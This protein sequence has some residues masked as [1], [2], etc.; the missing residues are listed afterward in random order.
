MTNTLL[1]CVC[2]ED[3]HVW[4]KVCRRFRSQTL[5]NR[6]NTFKKIKT[7]VNVPRYTELVH[8]HVS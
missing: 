4:H 5:S 3:E 1:C 2:S 6:T 7:V 8:R